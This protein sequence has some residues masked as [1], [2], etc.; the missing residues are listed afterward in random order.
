VFLGIDRL[1]SGLL[2]KFTWKFR[3]KKEKSQKVA[4]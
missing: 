2:K 4:K 3:K 1:L